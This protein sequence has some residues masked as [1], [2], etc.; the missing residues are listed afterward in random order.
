MRA[1]SLEF[2]VAGAGIVAAALAAAFAAALV[3]SLAGPAQAHGNAAAAPPVHAA[4]PRI[5]ETAFGRAGKPAD[6]RRTIA[7]GLDDRMRYTPSRIVVKRGETV[8]FRLSNQ[9]RQLHEMVLG[10]DAA[11]QE[12]AALMKKFPEM[13][14]AD[15]YMAHVRPGGSGQIVWQFTRRGEFRFA[16]LLPGHFEAGMVGTVVVE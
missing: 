3:V 12:H 14:H 7:V 6:V 9:G 11:L 16:C 10:T 2:T 4:D 8:R 13:E 1:T 5:E 15:A